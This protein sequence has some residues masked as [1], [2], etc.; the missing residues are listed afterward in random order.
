MQSEGAKQESAQGNFS[1]VIGAA[2][3]RVDGPLKTT[4]S[5]QYA[6]DYHLPGMVYAVPVTSTIADRK[7]VV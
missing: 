3:P 1:P 6:A 7:S 5:A 4:G 2:L